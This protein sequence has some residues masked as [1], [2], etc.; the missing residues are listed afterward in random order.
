MLDDNDLGGDARYVD[1]FV[2]IGGDQDVVDGI[3]VAQSRY[4]YR[5]PIALLV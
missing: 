1:P 4:V 2:I 5:M 3:E